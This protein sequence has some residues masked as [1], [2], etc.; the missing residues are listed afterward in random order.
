M[1]AEA[2]VER[3]V[4]RLIGDG[5][6]FQN[7]LATANA[8][9]KRT[10][11][12]LQSVGA[13]V[14]ALKV[15]LLALGATF[16]K[17]GAGMR[18]IGR[19]LTT[20]VTAPL[21][22]MAGVS[23]F[24]FSNFDKAMTESTSIMKVTTRQIE[25]MRDAAINFSASGELL[26]GPKELAESYFFLASAGKNAEQ[27]IALL[28]KVS[29][30]A[31]AGAFD[32]A[33]ATDLL[34]DAQ[35]ALGLTMEDTAADARQL[36][37]VGDVLVKANTLANASVQQF[38]TALTA[39]AGAAIK[40]FGKDV[41]E[42]VAVLAAL[43]DQGIKAEL[44]GNALDRVLR[45][46]AKSALD[47][48]AA[49]KK[50]GF[51]VF[52]SSGAM[53]NMA[54]I[55]GNLEDILGGLSTQQKVATLDMLGFEARVQGVILPLIGTS[56]AIREYEQQLRKAGGITQEVADKQMKSF[57]NQMKVMKN[58]LTVVAIEIGEVLAPMLLRLNK[59]IKRVIGAWR[60]L[61]PATKRVVVIVGIVVAAIAPM[62]IALGTFLS[63]I[64]FIIT[65]IGVALGAV[66][67]TVAFIAANIPI[68]LGVLVAVGATAVAIT[69]AWILAGDTIK[70]AFIVAIPIVR[71]FAV[72][73]LGFIFNIR[74]NL[75]LL[76]AWFTTNWRNIIADAITI[77]G[78]FAKNIIKNIGIAV[79]IATDVWEK[80]KLAVEGAW[81][82]ATALLPLL[83]DKA[84]IKMR[85]SILKWAAS[86]FQTVVD[87]LNPFSG[88]DFEPA[89]DLQKQ[90]DK[91]QTKIDAAGKA[92]AAGFK[93]NFEQESKK[94]DLDP[95]KGFKA[96]TQPFPKFNFDLPDF[97]D[98]FGGKDADVTVEGT[99]F[100][101]V[102]KGVE[103]AI[104][105]ADIAP[106][107]VPIQLTTVEAIDVGSIEAL[108]LL[109]RIPTLQVP[110]A[111]IP[112]P[113]PN[114]ARLIRRETAA[115][116]TRVARRDASPLGATFGAAAE[117]GKDVGKTA[118]SGITQMVGLLQQSLELQIEQLEEARKLEIE[119]SPFGI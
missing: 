97:S 54:D 88:G 118:A 53:R 108:L 1:A 50:L 10:V 86:T 67:A 46:S 107:R 30:F 9:S 102:A 12:V 68:I 35:S 73:T 60:A 71:N 56:N 113:E 109:S 18:R 112:R 96:K 55:V 13:A 22:I 75:A 87:A 85:Q 61:E 81:K 100:E 17:V 51:S 31:T 62:L 114:A 70:G 58:Q 19:T 5:T 84:L 115:E 117:A 78:L 72:K 95:L 110:K 89:V 16:R 105:A 59:V 94:F 65:G 47:N 116:A 111:Q 26:Q 82:A 63:G 36:A 28:P 103:D 37:R 23:V 6:S 104:A 99:G 39:K 42:G 34:T 38:S 74:E 106:V 32:M 101:G 27:S 69:A 11:G 66:A 57:A 43:A 52:D 90:L 92:G 14:T 41:E 44:A 7:M 98:L 64:G 76:A 119:S 93:N 48:A 80:W 45:L 25:E 24:A 2:E 4:V 77:F 20:F 8:S 33:L 40:S 79:E 3:L 15:R 21:L 83:I 91:V 29:A 49:H